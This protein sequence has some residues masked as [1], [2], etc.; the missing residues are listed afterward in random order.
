M[1][2]ANVFTIAFAT[3][4]DSSGTDSLAGY[5][6]REFEN[7]VTTGNNLAD[8]L[9][10]SDTYVSGDYM[11]YM[12][13]LTLSP[14]SWYYLNFNP[15]S[16]AS[17]LDIISA[18][19]YYGK[20][21]IIYDSVFLVD[22]E[23]TE[24]VFFTGTMSES[25]YIEITCYADDK[26]VVGSAFQVYAVKSFDYTYDPQLTSFEEDH[27]RI[28]P[29]IDLSKYSA[30]SGD[31]IELITIYEDITIAS[32]YTWD[33]HIY[34][35]LFN[36]SGKAINGGSITVPNADNDGN[37]AT[38]TLTPIFGTSY[39]S[40]RYTRFYKFE[41]TGHWVHS[42]AKNSDGTV[43][44]AQR[45]RQLSSVT[46]NY[47]NGNSVTYPYNG[48]FITTDSTDTNG[49][50]STS[51]TGTFDSQ[52]NLDIDYTY[53]R[54]D[55]SDNGQYYHNQVDSIY[56]NIPNYLKEN[57][58][59]LTDVR[60]SYQ[61]VRT[62]PIIVTDN[63][64]LYADLLAEA[65]GDSS[66][67]PSLWHFN[68]QV[69][70]QLVYDFTH[71]YDLSSPA[72]SHVT[73]ISNQDC[74]AINYIFLVEDVQAG[75][76][77][78]ESTVSQNEILNWLYDWTEKVLSLYPSEETV[79]GANGPIL[80]KFFSEIDDVTTIN[81]ASLNLS[82]DN[83]KENHN[84]F[85]EW[86]E[87]GFIYAIK[88]ISTDV[89]LDLSSKIIEISKE[90]QIVGNSGGLYFAEK[91]ESKLRNCL[92]KA[93]SS[94]STMYL[95]RFNVSQYRQMPLQASLNGTAYDTSNSEPAYMAEQDCYLDLHVLELSFENEIGNVT[96]VPVSS[97]HIDCVADVTQE[98]TPEQIENQA[99]QELFAP[100][101]NWWD[102]LL[103]NM[104]TIGKILAVL[105][106][107]VLLMFV[108]RLLTPAFRG[109]KNL[110]QSTKKRFQKNRNK[111][112][113]KKQGE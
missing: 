45:R 109:I 5:E 9:T 57:Y 111:Q 15:P 83:Y 101:V 20:A 97:N 105:L 42:Y 51:V 37:S 2:L 24:R 35:Y 26:T 28:F 16:S 100:L 8:G 85:E 44:T 91:D 49:V 1:L 93:K 25:P 86:S 48:E 89:S 17:G 53:Y 66:K 79:T 72:G 87:Y 74:N 50:K 80:S 39:S 12:Y 108:A 6:I 104:K 21:G 84:F 41:V 10:L 38:Y 68:S 7:A 46:L 32:D 82:A 64:T 40:T 81:V 77:Q 30:T 88:G 78:A 65:T 11:I 14:N 67:K 61:R 27:N 112:K 55:T 4:T 58:G 59:K 63:A 56:F 31:F 102:S 60:L 70:N 94:D 96:T 18:Y 98:K 36:P 19:L 54:T 75:V 90:S 106:G 62:T 23:S 43:N 13:R 99:T 29:N 110:F 47:A 71:N 107:L 113:S 3:G 73:S 52:V 92:A 76:R 95:V 33:G 69:G 34:L 22:S 103:D